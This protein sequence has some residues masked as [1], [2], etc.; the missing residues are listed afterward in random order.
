MLAFIDES[1][2][3]NHGDASTRPV[4]AVVCF[5]ESQS[6]LITR[7][8]Y[9]L[10]RTC[11]DPQQ[12][13]AE[14]K[15]KKL[16]KAETYRK[17]RASRIF[18]EE[19]F[20]VLQSWNLTVFATIMEAPFHRAPD[21]SGLLPRRFRYL[22][23]RMELL[24]AERETYANVLFDG[25]GSQFKTLS[26]LFAN[27]LYRSNEGQASVH[28]A[29]APA[30]VD[31]ATSAGIQIADM[32]AYVIRVYQE[33]HLFEAPPP[34]GDEYLHAIRRWYRTIQGLSRDFPTGGGTVRYGLQR[35]P[36]GVR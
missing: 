7:Q 34:S 18:V 27:F 29:D 26:R 36:R 30:F 10:K 25:R 17:S 5:D 35:L 22:L 19:F 15:G 20:A 33:Q 21:R 12:T 6:R 14:L 3:P 1:G 13:E 4:V 31:S 8:L 2:Q 16:L 23:Q 28:I 9:D 11:L 32:C 24:A